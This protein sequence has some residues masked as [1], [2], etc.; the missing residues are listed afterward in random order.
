MPSCAP[1]RRR[2]RVTTGVRRTGALVVIAAFAAAA[3]AGP[4][5]ASRISEAQMIAGIQFLIWVAVILSGARRSARS[6]RIPFAAN[7]C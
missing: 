4:A 1:K 7:K 2:S 6:R 3:L 5:D